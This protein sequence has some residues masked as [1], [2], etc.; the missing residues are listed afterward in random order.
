MKKLTH[1]NSKENMNEILTKIPI[2]AMKNKK[3]IEESNMCG[4]YNCIKVF[5]KNEIAEWTDNSQTALCPFC[6][7]DSVIADSVTTIN[8][9][10]LQTIKNYWLHK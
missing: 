9:E 7:V 3:H 5:H 2:Y 10:T 8:Q 4:C 6:K 1:Q